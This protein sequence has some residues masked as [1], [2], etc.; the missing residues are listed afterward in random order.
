[1]YCKNIIFTEA[2]LIKAFRYKDYFQLVPIFYSTKAPISHYASH[3]P[4]FLEYEADVK[5]EYIP[6]E[7]MLRENG[8]SE[9]V[10]K[11][12][13][14]LPSQ[15]RA[16]KE[17]LHL[18]SSLTNFSFYE[19]MGRNCWGI[20]T[21]MR[22]I[23]TL[24][25][26]EVDQ[27]NNQFSHWII[28]GYYYP[29]IAED[30]K[31]SSLTNCRDY[32]DAYDTPI[33]Y[34][35]INPNLESNSEIKIPPYLSFVLDRYYSLSDEEKGTVRQCLGLLYEGIELFNT[36]R[37]VSLL[38]VVSSIEG[39]A[40]LDLKVFGNG[41]VLGAKKCFVRYLKTYVAGKSEE[42]F[43]FYYEKRCEITHEG[44]LFL[45]DVDLYGDIKKQDEDWRF[46]LEVLQAARIAL[47]NW[48]R[49]KREAS[50]RGQASAV[51]AAASAAARPAWGAK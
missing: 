35:T 15:T 21:P 24:S 37:S 5:E 17:I 38:S 6:T 45:S 27:I 51:G 33:D 4:C 47:Y 22:D 31:I 43:K 44:A 28:G 20:Q 8:M 36:H 34:F 16:R 18:L 13:R 25:K 3:F 2:P 29:S 39:M 23:D 30:L 1:M 9:E 14:K 26:E 46:R 40:Q 42:K 19:Y 41:E 48:L 32:Y 50:S 49:R 7:Q 10:L 12:G 11:L